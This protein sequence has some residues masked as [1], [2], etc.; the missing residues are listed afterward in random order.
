MSMLS[1]KRTKFRKM[2][3]GRTRGFSKGANE[4][5]GCVRLRRLSSSPAMVCASRAPPVGG[6]ATTSTAA[7]T[8]S[9]TMS[10]RS[11][12]RRQIVEGYRSSWCGL[13]YAGP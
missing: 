2:Q 4:H 6:P 13:R 12:A 3:K 9:G 1:P 7:V 11:C 5:G 8:S 10:S